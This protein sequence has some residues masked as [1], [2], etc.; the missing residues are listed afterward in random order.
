MLWLSAWASLSVGKQVID[1]NLNSNRKHIKSHSQYWW[2]MRVSWYTIKNT[3][4]RC[5]WQFVSMLLWC[6]QMY[7]LRC[8]GSARLGPHLCLP[9][10]LQYAALT[11][12]FPPRSGSRRG[13]GS[14]RDAATP[15]SCAF[16]GRLAIWNL[17]G[18][19]S[20]PPLWKLLL[21][22]V[23]RRLWVLVTT[24]IYEP[25]GGHWQWRRPSS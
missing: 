14:E 10:G 5:V 16:Q 2:Q 1:K 17:S 13:P 20:N 11:A 12:T 18:P 19:C 15:R 23:T 21:G 4:Y 22:V 24:A 3:I 9:S 7:C 6:S 8:Q 25:A